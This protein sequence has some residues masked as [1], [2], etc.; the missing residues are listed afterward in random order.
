M[1]VTPEGAR[2]AFLGMV[3]AGAPLHP[4]A[5]TMGLRLTDG[6]LSD[7]LALSAELELHGAGERFSIRQNT[8]KTQRHASHEATGRDGASE[9]LYFDLNAVS[10]AIIVTALMAEMEEK[11][12]EGPPI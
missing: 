6:Q 4:D 9:G 5:V 12:V 1:T 8:S 2:G 10:T 11:S 7:A 3:I